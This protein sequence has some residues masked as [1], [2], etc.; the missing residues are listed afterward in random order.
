MKGIILAGGLGT[1]MGVSTKVTNKH[2]LAVYDYPMVH[3]PLMTLLKA[4]IENILIVSGPEHSGDFQKYFNPDNKNIKELGGLEDRIEYYGY[5]LNL[6][7]KTQYGGSKGIAHALN[8]AK[9]FSNKENLAVILGDNFLEDNLTNE[10]SQFTSGAK[11]FLKE[12]QGPERFGVAEVRDNRVISIEEKPKQPKTNLAV[13]G[14]YL[15]DSKVFDIIKTLKPSARGEYE[16]TDV[17]NAYIKKREVS[18]YILG[19]FW[20]DMGTPESLLRTANFIK[21][22]E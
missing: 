22:N 19:G 10:I 6:T 18:Y 4:N 13:T 3:Y 5:K 9:E 12:V 17:N 7:Y 8:C 1:R 16:I 14:L 2:L 11:I 20:S 15:Y 21:Q